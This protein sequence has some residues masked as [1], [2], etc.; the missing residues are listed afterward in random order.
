MFRRLTLSVTLGALMLTASCAE[1]PKQEEEPAA[2]PAAAPVQEGPFYELTKDEIT[3]HP[4]WTSKNI[5]FKGLKIGDKGA[6]TIEK[7]IGKGDKD[8]VVPGIGDHYRTIYGQ[9]SFAIYTYKNTAELQ[10]I[11]IYGKIADQIAD[12]KF[13]RLLST[14]DLKF[15]RDTFGMEE[16]AEDNPNTSGKEYIYDAK[17]FRFVQYNYPGQKVNA[18]IFSKLVPKKPETTTETKAPETK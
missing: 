10:K 16:K 13:K 3:S 17:G 12:P 15:M 18:I 7:A 8:Q 6:A 4:D 9:S 2:A 14:G 11:E 1:A 5:T